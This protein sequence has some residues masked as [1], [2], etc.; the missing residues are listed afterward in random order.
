MFKKGNLCKLE[1]EFFRFSCVSWHVSI[2]Q[3]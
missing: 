3:N 1:S 2:L